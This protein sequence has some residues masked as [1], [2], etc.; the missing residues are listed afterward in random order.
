[1]KA[2]VDKLASFLCDWVPCQV[3]CI[4]II[5]KNLDSVFQ[6]EH[7]FDSVGYATRLFG[8]HLRQQPCTLLRRLIVQQ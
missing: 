4:N 5:N 6:L 3:D 1:M 7:K 8:T 2:C